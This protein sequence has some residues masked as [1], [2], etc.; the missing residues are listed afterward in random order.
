MIITPKTKVLQL[1][2][3]YPELED[4][5]INMVPAFEKL[6]NPVLRKTVAKIATLQQ[7]ASIGHLKTEELINKLRKAVGQEQVENMGADT[8]FITQ[9]PEWFDAAKVVVEFD[10]RKMLQ[11][12]E[13]PVNQ[14][15]SDLNKLVAGEIYK[16]TAPFLPAPLIEKAGSLKIRHWV[17]QENDELFY[18]YFSR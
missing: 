7:A 10:V 14:V 6:K 3:T 5:L 16:L 18:I 9:Q 2:E 12:G 15:I 11:A 8:H 1:I 13:H 4:V 17:V